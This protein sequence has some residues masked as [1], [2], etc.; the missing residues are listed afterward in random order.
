M[1]RSTLHFARKTVGGQ[2]ASTG[3]QTASRQTPTLIPDRTS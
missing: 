3:G 1:T 2:C